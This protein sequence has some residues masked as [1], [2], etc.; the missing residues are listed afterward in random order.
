MTGSFFKKSFFYYFYFLKILLN[1]L[2]LVFLRFKRIYKTQR[3]N[4]FSFYLLIFHL[5]F[6]NHSLYWC[7]SPFHTF[8][9]H[10]NTQDESILFFIVLGSLC[11]LCTFCAWT[12]SLKRNPLPYKF[13]WWSLNFLTIRLNSAEIRMSKF[14]KSN[15]RTNSPCCS[16]LPWTRFCFL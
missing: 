4:L 6:C 2:E 15:I 11:V 3:T 13:C 16:V 9:L 10:V 8:L 7:F 1:N 14:S 12:G 5:L